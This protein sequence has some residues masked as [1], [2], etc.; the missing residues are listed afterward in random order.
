MFACQLVKGPL[1]HL[2]DLVVAVFEDVGVVSRGGAVA[3]PVERLAELDGD[4]CRE[5]ER[6]NV[7]GSQAKRDVPNQ[8]EYLDVLSVVTDYYSG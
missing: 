5:L 6:R 2:R 3:P 1:H 8:R 4:L 7:G